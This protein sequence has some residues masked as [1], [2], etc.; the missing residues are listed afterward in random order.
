[1]IEE[2][3]PSLFKIEIPLP[4][5]PLKSLNAYVIKG[6]DRFLLIDTGMNRKECIQEM[7]S[8]LE[9]LNVD[10]TKTDLFITHLHADHLG[11][12][13]ILA[14]STSK[15]YFNRIESSYIN[16]PERWQEAHNYYLANGFPENE[17]K[18]SMERHPGYQYGLRQKV[19]FNIVNEGDVIEIGDYRFNCIETPGHSPGHMCLYEAKQN[20]LVS[21]DHV[22]FDITPNITY[23]PGVDN[24]LK[25]YIESLNKIYNFE[26]KLVLP[27]HRR[28]WNNHRDRIVELK[29]HHETR[30]NEVLSALKYGGENAFEIAP[31]ITWDIDCDS[32]EEFPPTQK[33]FAFGETI[34]HLEYLEENRIVRRSAKNNKITFSLVK[35]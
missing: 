15:V 6:N 26:V 7:T 20:I 13:A 3:L 17:L 12:A 2:I 24:S 8:S 22:L 28:I 14:T 25:K 23:W 27:G 31:H 30:V 11:L 9:K 10:L 5:N 33:W 1:M 35:Y 16:R 21:G 34:A 32:W 29:R 19:R 4:N 18:K